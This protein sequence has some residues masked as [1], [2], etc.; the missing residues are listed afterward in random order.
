MSL[1]ALYNKCSL[2][3][4]FLE[5]F[6]NTVEKEIDIME[7]DDDLLTHLEVCNTCREI[8]IVLSGTVEQRV[9]DV[10]EVDRI[11]NNIDTILDG[12]YQNSKNPEKLLKRPY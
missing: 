5:L 8:L 12:A 1:N 3:K 7:Y 9:S 6:N 4:K 2:G 10:E 11:Y